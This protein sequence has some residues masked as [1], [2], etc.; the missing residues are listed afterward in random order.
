[1]RILKQNVLIPEIATELLEIVFA[2]LDSL[3]QHAKEV[4][5]IYIIFHTI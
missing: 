2:L 3:V 1:V 4:K 5:T